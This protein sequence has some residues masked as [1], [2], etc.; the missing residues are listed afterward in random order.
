MGVFSFNLDTLSDYFQS[1]TRALGCKA[2]CGS[3]RASSVRASSVPRER[4]PIAKA[5]GPTKMQKQGTQEELVCREDSWQ[6]GSTRASSRS[7]RSTATSS[8]SSSN[9]GADRRW[10]K[11]SRKSTSTIKST[12]TSNSGHSKWSVSLKSFKMGPNPSMKS[13]KSATSEAQSGSSAL[14]GE[15]HH[16]G[17]R[18]TMEDE[19]VYFPNFMKSSTTT[20]LA[21][22]DGHGGRRCVD[23]VKQVLHRNFANHVQEQPNNISLAFTNAFV[24]TDESLQTLGITQSG[25]TACCCFMRLELGAWYLYTAHVGDTRAVL[26]RGGSAYRLT[27]L[28]DHKPSDPEEARRII[29]AGG[30]IN[31]RRVN[32]ALAISRALG[33]H[34]LKTPLQKQSIVSNIPDVSRVEITEQDEF[35]VVA[36]D[37]LWDVMEDQ[38]AVEIVRDAAGAILERAKNVSSQ[39]VASMLAQVLV[40]EALLR[41]TTDNVTCA[42]I[43]PV[44]PEV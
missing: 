39:Q 8:P 25:C 33:D 31:N 22:Y 32:G 19:F 6:S 43:F 20:F 37:G 38:E 28:S 12:S 11:E 21:V 27:A 36:C 17:P 26:S 41:G 4:T 7:P 34:L 16:I 3:V 42:I 9:H 2:T 15:A 29:Q 44:L 1:K 18:P 30:R 24:E 10:S 5:D 13:S 35:I 23:F 14:V 40:K